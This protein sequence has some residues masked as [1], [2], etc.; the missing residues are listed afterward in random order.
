[1]ALTVNFTSSEN[2]SANQYVSFTDTSTGS[3]GSIVTRRIYILQADG[4]YLV[5]SGTLTDYIL[6]DY[7]DTSI[8]LDLLTK[9]TSASVK[10]EWW[11]SVAKV[12]ELT[13]AM[14]WDLYDYVFLF[15]LLQTQTSQPLIIS[16]ANYYNNIMAMIVNL[17]QS[18][19]AITKMD[20][21]FSSQGALD[22]NQWLINN[23]SNYF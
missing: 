12:Y 10:V 4:T 19:N 3:D 20:D 18:E 9:S 11:D 13:Q 16:D 7:A 6:W 8:T 5:P 15:G 22:R 17:F 14:E 1:M 21:I 23:Q 2:L